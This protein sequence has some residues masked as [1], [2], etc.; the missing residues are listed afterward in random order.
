MK[1]KQEATDL[2]RTMSSINVVLPHYDNQ[3]VDLA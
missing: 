3:V 1:S 2:A